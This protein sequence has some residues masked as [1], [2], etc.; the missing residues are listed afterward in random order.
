LTARGYGLTLGIISPEDTMPRKT[1]TVTKTES[2]RLINAKQIRDL[3]STK[4]GM[5]VSVEALAMFNKMVYRL[6]REA[7]GRTH[8]N[9]QKTIRSCDV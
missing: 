3:V 6:V 7:A 8:A 5:T 2:P 1:K 9:G 4:T